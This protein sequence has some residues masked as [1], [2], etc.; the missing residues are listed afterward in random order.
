[1]DRISVDP[2]LVTC[3]EA[4]EECHR[5]CAERCREMAQAAQ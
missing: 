2:A 5:V 4:R 3:I 1:M